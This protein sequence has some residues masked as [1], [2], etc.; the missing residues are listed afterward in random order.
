M[1]WK[2]YLKP[3]ALIISAVALG[4][5]AYYF[6]KT[7]PAIQKAAVNLFPGSQ[8]TGAENN[9]GVTVEVP[10]F[11]AL[12]NISIFDYWLNSKTNSIYY[13]NEAGQI[14][15]NNNG[16]E[17]LVNSQSLQKLN[18]VTASPDGNYILAKFNYPTLPTFSIFNTI[19]NSWQ[20]L[21]QNT[22]AAAWS[23][24]SQKIAYLDDKSLKILNILTQKTQEVLKFSQKEIDLDWR[25][26]NQILIS[27][28]YGPTTKILSFAL[29]KKTLTPFLEEFGL[30][31]KWSDDNLF[32]IKLNTINNKPVTSIID[33][34][35]TVLTQLTFITIPSK[36]LIQQHKIYCAVPQNISEQLKLPE[37]YY[38]KVVYFDDKLYLIDLTNG[39]VSE[40]SAD[41]NVPIDA[42]HLE[43]SQG[44]LYFKN[45]LDDKLYSLAL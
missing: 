27:S 21:P 28:N 18:K 15:K 4:V 14:I 6:F 37:D 23:P 11:G 22:I 13:L 45:R 1:N 25:F 3:L 10:K 8:K 36:C 29:D 39:G 30:V 7:N 9:L 43:F 44:K 5:L 31:I 16:N 42:D 20:S 24:D 34:N 41:I 12:T 35:G 17:E 38:K 26:D 40:I 33:A 32:G 19:T 2:K